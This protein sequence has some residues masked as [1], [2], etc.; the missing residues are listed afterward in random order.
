MHA[1]EDACA[2]SLVAP[3]YAPSVAVV[4]SK[5]WFL[6]FRRYSLFQVVCHAACHDGH[7]QGLIAP[8]PLPSITHARPYPAHGLA[9]HG[10]RASRQSALVHHHRWSI[11]DAG[12]ASQT[13]YGQLA[14]ASQTQYG[15]M[16]SASPGRLAARCGSLPL[17]SCSG[18]QGPVFY[19]C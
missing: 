4:V 9:E 13:Q 5:T 6:K 19:W 7:R 16:A 3:A 2:T 12:S 11:S 18:L 8:P 1:L 10:N 15:Q 17:T 14:S